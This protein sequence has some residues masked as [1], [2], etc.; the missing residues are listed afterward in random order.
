MN[1]KDV[2]VCFSGHRILKDPKEEV[3]ANLEAAIRQC[4]DNGSEV[5]MTGGALGFDTL[6]AWTVIRLKN[7]YPRI[8]LVLA[9]P[10][11]TEEQSIKWTIKQKNEY[12]QILNQADEVRI[13]SKVYTDTC[14]LDRNDYMVDNS[15]TIVYYLRYNRGGTKHT[16]KYAQSK[17]IQMIG[18]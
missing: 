1:N 4:I 10:C 12:Q 5:F 7:E 11:P 2:T 14:M 9:L 13:L 3:E 17:G 15:S 6:A 8:Q 16:V 18:I